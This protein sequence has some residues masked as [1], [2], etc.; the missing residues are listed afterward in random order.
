[1]SSPAPVPDKKTQFLPVSRVTRVILLPDDQYILLTCGHQNLSHPTH[2]TMLS[3]SPC[4]ARA[5]AVSTV[6]IH[7]K[8]R[9]FS[10]L[11]PER[12]DRKCFV[13]TAAVT[14]SQNSGTRCVFGVPPARQSFSSGSA[15]YPC[16]PLH[17]FVSALFL[18]LFC[19]RF[20]IHLLPTRPFGLSVA[21][22][23][24][25]LCY[26]FAT[27][28]L[29]NCYRSLFAHHQQ[30]TLAM[31]TSPRRKGS[32]SESRSSLRA[33]NPSLNPTPL[34]RF[35]PRLAAWPA[36][37]ERERIP[38]PFTAI[39]YRFTNPFRAFTGL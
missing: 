19:Y 5:E 17:S 37:H 12:T 29:S 28:L 35:L 30:G 24:L 18:L 10:G 15:R 26:L 4:A 6:V 32:P 13:A 33:D 31:Y 14:A 9:N 22:L 8:M 21:T 36:P 25:L 34:Q 38:R 27:P 16:L 3:L 2:Y 11:L 20:A 1:M 7:R 23:L 39:R